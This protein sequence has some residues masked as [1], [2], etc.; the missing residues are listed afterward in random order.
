MKTAWIVLGLTGWFIL[1]TVVLE[2]VYGQD[3]SNLEAVFQSSTVK[4]G[5][6]IFVLLLAVV[7]LRGQGWLEGFLDR[8][9]ILH[10]VVKVVLWCG[11]AG[12]AVGLISE[13]V[14]VG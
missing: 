14:W 12:W 8:H 2:R 6:R 1:A 4:W 7:L 5:L 13:F 9:V 3:L 11:I 10:R